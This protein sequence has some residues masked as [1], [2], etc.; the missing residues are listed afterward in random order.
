MEKLVTA[1]SDWPIIV[2]GALGSALFWLIL[3]TGQKLTAASISYFSKRSNNN[4]VRQ[5]TLQRLK[6]RALMDKGNERT[7]SM[8]ALVYVGV[9]SI[10]KALVWITL[11]LLFGSLLDIFGIVGFIG[12][13]YYLFRAVDVFSAI[14]T[15]VDHA[16]KVAEIDSELAV[17]K[18]HNE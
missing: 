16:K 10:V 18:K 17:L 13:L 3:I 1:F 15:D 4:R 6:Y 11:G 12:G 5:L 14:D 2:Q 7:S 8:I 9:K